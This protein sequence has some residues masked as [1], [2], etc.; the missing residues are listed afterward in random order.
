[1]IWFVPGG[2]PPLERL[3]VTVAEL[4]LLVGRFASPT[5]S[6]DAYSTTTPVGAALPLAAETVAVT[7]TALVGEVVDWLAEAEIAVET[8]PLVATKVIAPEV[9]AVA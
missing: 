1:M 9:D 8:D 7:V 5:I 6:S 2:R 4:L 3:N